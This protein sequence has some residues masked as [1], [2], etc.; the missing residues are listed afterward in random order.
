MRVEKHFQYTVVNS[1][2]K[3]GLRFFTFPEMIY[4]TTQ[5]IKKSQT[6][7]RQAIGICIGTV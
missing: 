6:E 4:H 5:N 3:G 2:F 1:M 7:G